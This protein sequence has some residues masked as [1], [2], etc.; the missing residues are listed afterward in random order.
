MKIRLD[1]VTN[2]SSVSF[3]ISMD[4]DMAEFFKKKNKDFQDDP[5]K[6]RIY[7]LLSSDIAATGSPAGLDGVDLKVKAY[8]FEKK[9]DCLYDKDLRDSGPEADLAGLSDQELWR[10]IH[11]EYLVKARLAAELKGFGSI[12]VPRDRQRIREKYCLQAGCDDCAKRDT[13]NCHSLGA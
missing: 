4:A 10:Y 7:G 5:L 9:G 6:G 12:Q 13:L 1:Y 2:S 3:I 8:H 11:G